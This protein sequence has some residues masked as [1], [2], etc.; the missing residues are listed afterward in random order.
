MRP[1]FRAR[2]CC[3][4]CEAGERRELCA[5]P[6]DEPRM[7]GFLRE[8]YAGRVP[9]DALRGAAYRVVA[10]ERCEFLFQ[11]PV[12]DDDGMR[13]LYVHW[14]DAA[15]SLRKK[16]AGGQALAR[17]YAGQLRSMAALLR[18]PPAAQRLL[19]FGMGWGYWCRAAQDRGFQISGYELS[20]ERRDYARAMGVTVIDELPPPG[21]HFDGIYSA[22]VFEH[23]AEPRQT[24]QA[25]VARLAPGGLV[26]LRVPDG[27]GIA[28]AL[29][30]EGW[31]PE[32]EAIH[33]LE[34]INCV[35]RATLV[36][37]AAAA[38]LRRVDPPPRLSWRSPWGS[39]KR[40]IAD[41]YLNTHLFFRYAD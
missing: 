32:L 16:Q 10:C 20:A 37:L 4:V 11:D 6:F 36:R 5:I 40:E 35:T 26:Y 25:L 22:Q 13:L 8:F 38:G 7:A 27:R 34:H 33:P 12:L 21:A 2:A 3:P 14:I 39:L 29:R 23:L 31:S 15:R 17:R 24:L 9:L 19:E 28:R 30:D 1:G 41:R 18:G